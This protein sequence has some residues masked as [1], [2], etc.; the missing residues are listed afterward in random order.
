MLKIYLQAKGV[1]KVLLVKKGRSTQDPFFSLRTK[2][3]FSSRRPKACGE[4]F[5]LL[6]KHIRKELEVESP[7]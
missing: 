5:L 7:I 3:E 2:P 6:L 1:H 4:S